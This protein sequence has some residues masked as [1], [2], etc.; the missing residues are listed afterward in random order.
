MGWNAERM[1]KL[2]VVM[3]K[4]G[5]LLQWPSLV[6]SFEKAWFT[7]RCICSSEAEVINDIRD[8]FA[9]TI[10]VQIAGQKHG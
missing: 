9:L 10:S 3:S 6:D 8:S 2:Q 4:D 5:L 1:W 7:E